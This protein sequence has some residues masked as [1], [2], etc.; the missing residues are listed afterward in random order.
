M[1]KSMT[2]FGRCE[3]VIN[4]RDI[5]IE[6]KSVN[7]RYF[8]FSSRITRGYGFLDEKFKSYLQSKISRGKIDVY[9]FIE[10]MEDTDA[11]VLVNHSLAAGYVNALRELAQRYSLRDDISV[12]TVSRYSDI[13]TVHKAPEDEQII[14]DS[15]RQ[16]TDQ[17]LAAF[18]KMREIEG[19]RLKADVLQR[20]ETILQTVGKIEERS[21]QTVSEYQQ[22][23]T[24]KLTELLSD[25]NIDEQRILTETAIFADK[26]AVSEETVR[27]RS[28]FE[29]FSNM[30]NS[31]EAIGRKLD[32]IVQEMN[33]EANTIGSK[34]ID[35]QIAYMV[36][37]IKAEIEK[38][39]EQ[40]QN[41]E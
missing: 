4:G 28:H 7:H 25:S 3:E 40:I 37:D 30:L 1:I 41:I 13:F 11:Q 15:V 39:R 31:N 10:T 32:F 34:C 5:I 23:L 14:W 38:I 16:V 18:L 17:A 19:E 26:I 35:S 33:R 12:G 2:G 22:K 24:Q 9:A 8:E 27:L 21:P 36:V 6:I 29:Q 20:A